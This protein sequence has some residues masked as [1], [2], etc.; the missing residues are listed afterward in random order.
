M[1]TAFASIVLPVPEG[2]VRISKDNRKVSAKGRG[3][4]G[5]GSLASTYWYIEQIRHA[6]Q[7]QGSEGSAVVVGEAASLVMPIELG[8]KEGYGNER[9]GFGGSVVQDYAG[10]VGRSVR[11]RDEGRVRVNELLYRAGKTLAV[12]AIRATR[13][14]D[15]YVGKPI[16]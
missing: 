12:I 15:T 14:A 1:A 2:S 10:V 6:S 9:Y 13:R 8:Q 16:T 4:E 3:T 11:L 5:W 7:A